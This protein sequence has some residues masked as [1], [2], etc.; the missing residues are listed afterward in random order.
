MVADPAAARALV[1]HVLDTLAALDATLAEEAAHVRAGRLREGLGAGGPKA[2]LA[3]AYMQGLEVAKANAVALA[4]F[5]P[6][7]VEALR[8]AHRRFTATVEANQ[9]V[10]AAA[11]QVS[12][13]LIK[14]LAA[15]IGRAQ[16]PTGYGRA[17]PAPSPYGRGVRS[18]PLVLSRSL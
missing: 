5:H 9:L 12:E 4:R 2:A 6:Q 13:G 15:E 1:A 10:L 3:G 17:A 7:G 14:S 16:A 11:R 8:A 18:G